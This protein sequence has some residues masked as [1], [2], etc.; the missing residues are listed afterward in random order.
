MKMEPSWKLSHQNTQGIQLLALSEVTS[1]ECDTV[2]DGSQR[3][4][5]GSELE[6]EDKEL[7]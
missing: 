1:T 4:Q 5:P 7:Q 2:K 6:T 3:K